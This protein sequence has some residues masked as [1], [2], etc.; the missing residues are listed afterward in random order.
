MAA[1]LRRDNASTLT[2][3]YMLRSLDLTVTPAGAIEHAAPEDSVF[4]PLFYRTFAISFWVTVLSVVLGYPV[5]YVI[6]RSGRWRDI[7][8]CANC[9]V[10]FQKSTTRKTLSHA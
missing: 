1:A 7:G 8:V 6:V 2:P 10:T 9:G 3:I 4:R 5:A